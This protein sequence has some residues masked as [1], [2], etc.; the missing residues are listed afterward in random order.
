MLSFL[1]PLFL[2]G[3]V[4]A[5]VPIVLHLLK[6]EPEPRV[7]FA[8]VKLLKQAPVEYTERVA[9]ASCCC[10]RCVSPRSSFFALAFARPF[11][12]SGAAISS[13]GVTIVALDTS[14]SM[15]APGVFDRAKQLA[16]AAINK[17]PAGDLV[18]VVTFADAPNLAARAAPDRALARSAIDAAT[19]GFGATRYRGALSAAVQ[20]FGGRRGTIVVVTDL[21]ESGWDAG[22]RG[23]V[24]ESAHASRLP[25]WGRRRRTWPSQPFA[26]PATGLSRRCG[27]AATR[28]GPLA[29][30]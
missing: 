17:A 4:T 16:T 2:I 20:A 29:R 5:A 26:P 28:R 22:D 1:S 8:A 14:Y 12:A 25:T 19:P 3:A 10:W 6:R 7:K 13:A 27:T 15:S 9:F 21:Q 23:S 18:G 24:P 30:G 11:L